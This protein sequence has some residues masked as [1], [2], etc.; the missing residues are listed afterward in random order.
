MWE[1][2]ENRES[3]EYSCLLDAVQSLDS[4]NQ[5]LALQKLSQAS[6]DK[7][8]ADSLLTSFVSDLLDG[9]S[10]EKQGSYKSMEVKISFIKSLAKENGGDWGFLESDPVRQAIGKSILADWSSAQPP[11][12]D[13]QAFAIF[14]KLCQLGPKLKGEFAESFEPNMFLERFN[15]LIA[16]EKSDWVPSSITKGSKRAEK[17]RRNLKQEFTKIEIENGKN[18]FEAERIA[19]NKLIEGDTKNHLKN[20]EQKLNFLNKSRENWPEMWN[21]IDEKGDSGPSFLSSIIEEIEGAWTRPNKWS[22]GSK[23]EI[24]TVLKK[25]PRNIQ[26][27]ITSEMAER[28]AKGFSLK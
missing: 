8:D 24:L 4:P 25:Q 9:V 5:F 13:K 18:K 2:T 1:R 23:D 16:K 12:D 22:K 26:E 20:L 17:G 6:A 19:N 14:E 3:P 11:L 27:M 21:R 7:K 15:H 10:S 28:I